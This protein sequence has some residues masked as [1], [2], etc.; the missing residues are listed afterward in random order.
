MVRRFNQVPTSLAKELYK[1]TLGSPPDQLPKPA[2]IRWKHTKPPKLVLGERRKKS[3][4][5]LVRW[6]YSTEHHQLDHS[7]QVPL[8]GHGSPQGL[9]G[10]MVGLPQE[11]FTINGNQ[12]VIDT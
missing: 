6:Y 12:L 7:S 11:R 10:F 5:Y 4:T 2:W 8:H 3:A 9:H 1:V